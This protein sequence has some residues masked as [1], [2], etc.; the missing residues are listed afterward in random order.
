MRQARGSG[1]AAALGLS[2]RTVLHRNFGG[3]LRG[4][5]RGKERIWEQQPETTRPELQAPKKQRKDS[6]CIA[7][8]T[9]AYK[10]PGARTA[11]AFVQPPTPTFA[12]VA[13]SQDLMRSSAAPAE[14]APRRERALHGS[15]RLR[16]QGG[17]PRRHR[18]RGQGPL[19]Q[20]FLQSRPRP[21]HRR[22]TRWEGLT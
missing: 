20:G 11:T 4:N 1:D 9:K 12:V 15:R 18:Q 14:E 10:A 5:E 3:Q 22:R 13:P 8:A 7:P 16:V 21:P 19:P 17:R 6:M 2:L